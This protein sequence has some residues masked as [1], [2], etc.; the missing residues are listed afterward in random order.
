[1]KTDIDALKK[2][3]ED[4]VKVLQEEKAAAVKQAK[5]KNAK[6]EAGE[7]AKLR[8][9]DNHLKILIGAA[10]LAGMRKTGKIES[11]VNLDTLAG[12]LKTDRD[13]ALITAIKAVILG[14]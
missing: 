1:M 8:K 2:K 11:T 3:Y 5:A 14:K 10:A 6:M 12:T 9:A 7:K 4:K 13:K